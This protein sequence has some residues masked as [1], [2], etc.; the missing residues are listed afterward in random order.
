MLAD[1]MDTLLRKCA[2]DPRL[3]EA[4]RAEIE[5]R[6]E[7]LTALTRLLHDHGYRDSFRGEIMIPQDVLRAVDNHRLVNRDGEE[8]PGIEESV[9]WNYTN[10]VITVLEMMLGPK[11]EDAIDWFNA[12]SLVNDEA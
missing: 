3:C 8:Q 5:R 11:P 4:G 6:S 9:I 1:T 2:R 7:W 12:S 10:T